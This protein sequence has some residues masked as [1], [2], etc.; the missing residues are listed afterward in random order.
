MCSTSARRPGGKTTHLAALMAG[1]GEVVAVEVHPGRAQALRRDLRADG[2][3]S[4]S[5]WCRSMLASSVDRRPFD[6]VLVDPPCSGLGTLQSRPDLRWQPRRAEI[7]ELAAKQAELLR[8]GAGGC[9]RVARSSIRSARSAAERPTPSWTGCVARARRVQ[10]R[11]ALAA[12]PQ[13]R[14]DRRLLHR[15]APTGGSDRVT[16]G[17]WTRCT[18]SLGRIARTA[19]SRG[20]DRR[21]SPGAT[22]A[23]T[24]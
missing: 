13:H 7:D 24:A 5:G 19:T 8:A 9:G 12:A 22:G 11:A 20:C 2:R 23:C 17:T 1:E 6:R 14:R 3:G 15:A 18:R 16:F 10:L 21:P 4:A